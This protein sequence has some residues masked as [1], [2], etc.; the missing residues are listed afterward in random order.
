MPQL[1]HSMKYPRLVMA[2]ILGFAWFIAST[3]DCDG[4]DSNGQNDS[5]FCTNVVVSDEQPLVIPLR[6]SPVFERISKPLPRAAV[7]LEAPFQPPRV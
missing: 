7:S 4:D 3:T 5:L 1:I 6:V 2:L